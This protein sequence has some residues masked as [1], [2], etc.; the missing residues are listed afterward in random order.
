M[1]SMVDLVLFG[2][3]NF[4]FPAKSQSYEVTSKKST[5]YTILTALNLEKNKMLCIR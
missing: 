4:C 5:A 1:Y 3:S 2:F